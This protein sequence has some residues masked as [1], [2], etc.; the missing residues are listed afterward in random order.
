MRAIGDS[1]PRRLKAKASGAIAAGKPLI[2]EADGDVAQIAE[3]SSDAPGF[4]SPA[5]FESAETDN[6]SVAYDA[7][8][9][10]IVVAYRD[11]GNSNY[12][13]A[14]VGTVSGTSISFGTPVVYESGGSTMY[15]AIA[16]DAGAQKVVIAFSLRTGSKSGYAIVGTVSGTSISFGSSAQFESGDTRDIGIAYDSNVAKVVI[17]YRDKDNSYYATG[18]V[19][20]V[21]STSISFGTAT[22]FHSA[23]SS[24]MTVADDSNANKIVVAYSAADV[25]TAIVGTVSGT[26]ISFGSSATFESGQTLDIAIVYDAN[27]QKVV[28]AYRD[29][30]DNS[31]GKAIVGTVS[32]TDISF[33]TAVAFQDPQ[34]YEIAAAYDA[35]AQK[36]IISYKDGQNSDYGTAI[37]GTVSGTSISFGSEAVFESA[38]VTETSSTYDS[39]AQKVVTVYKDNGNSNY[40][41]AVVM[42]SSSTATN[43][44][45]EN[46]IGIAEYAAADTETATVLIKGGVSTP[47][48][49][50]LS[51]PEAGTAAEFESGAIGSFAASVYD[52]DTNRII[53]AYN[54]VGDSDKGK[55][56]VGTVSG[57]S[58]S[59]GTPVEFE[60]GGTTVGGI[61]YDTNANR[62]V[63]NYADSGNSSYGTAIVGTVS[64]TSISFGTAVVYNS[65]ESTEQGITFDSSNNKVVICY[66]DN[67]NSNHGTA[68]VGTVYNSD[69]SISFGSEVSYKSANSTNNTATFAS[70]NNKVVIAYRDGG[71][72]NYGT[73]IVGTVSGTSI[74]FG[75]EVVFAG[76]SAVQYN[77]AVF[78]SSNNKVVIAYRDDGNSNYGTTI[79]GTVS[80]TS[81]SFGTAVVFASSSTVY[82]KAAFDSGA[83]Q[84]GIAWRD[85]G[86]GQ[87]L[88][89]IVGTVSGT[90]ISFG[91]SVELAGDVEQSPVAYDSS[92]SQF[93]V[94]YHDDGDSSKGKAVVVSTLFSMTPAQTYFVQT[95]GSLGLTAGSPSVT[96]GTAVTSTKLIVKG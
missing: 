23:N 56:A 95:D 51:T 11:V 54:D 77:S 41:T 47:G 68:I 9:N 30:G 90:S 4:G 6:T 89:F 12:G 18:I 73:A 74:S 20:T 48:G 79:V 10:K 7:N 69:N 15:N 93:V 91:T 42:T 72:S 67:A 52:P 94:S 85:D 2:V 1:L 65:G 82:A 35:N 86:D 81:I 78:D 5:V 49:T 36:V 96:A 13:T 28:I 83:N 22:V 39:T 27:A 87:A 75:S 19:G 88:D 16:Y 55:A 34:G 32:G 3:T 92:S 76:S 57:T 31:A 8:A 21:S 29:G 66:R 84:V 60:A 46:Y 53:V 59:F 45:S 63:I 71:N 50:T 17:A 61:T 40:G 44:T 14:V 80:G 37:T 62:V 38:E 58:I 64:G 33:G 70:S 26:S 43:L 25:G 24:K